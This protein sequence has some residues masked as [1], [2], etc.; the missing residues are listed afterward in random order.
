MGEEASCSGSLDVPTA[1]FNHDS[2]AHARAASDWD[3]PGWNAAWSAVGETRTATAC[4]APG[5]NRLVH[6]SAA[7]AGAVATHAGLDRSTGCGIPLDRRSGHTFPTGRQAGSSDMSVRQGRD[8]EVTDAWFGPGRRIIEG[9][10]QLPQMALAVRD[11]VNADHQSLEI[12]PH[13]GAPEY[14]AV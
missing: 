5:P 11:V 8:S 12:G 4:F 2:F 6:V 3:A 13:P 9:A 7:C 1:R 14:A 10:H